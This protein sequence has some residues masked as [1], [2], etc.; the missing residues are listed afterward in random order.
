ML[1]GGQHEHNNAL[2][3]Q[4]FEVE[5]Y[6]QKQVVRFLSNCWSCRARSAS[7]IWTD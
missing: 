7:E 2:Y 6:T 3:D 1:A 5:R 4:S